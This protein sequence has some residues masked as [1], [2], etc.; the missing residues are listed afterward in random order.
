[1]L[2]LEEALHSPALQRH[3]PRRAV[4]ATGHFVTLA[5]VTGLTT[6]TLVVVAALMGSL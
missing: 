4:R 6:G 1:M 5:V 3:A 2:A